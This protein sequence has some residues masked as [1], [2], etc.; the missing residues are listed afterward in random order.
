VLLLAYLLIFIPHGT[1]R[2]VQAVLGISSST[3]N[4]ER[5]RQ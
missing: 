3:C 1:D 5:Q 2:I 4:Q